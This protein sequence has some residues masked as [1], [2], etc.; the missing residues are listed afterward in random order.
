MPAQNLFSLVSLVLLG[1]AV[2]APDSLRLSPRKAQIC[3]DQ[4]TTDLRCYT[5]P[6]NTPQNVAVADVEYVATY[7]RAYGAQIKA[8]RLYTMTAANAPDCDE[9][10]I[11]SHGSAMAVAKHLDSSL[12]SSV[13]FSDIA[14]TIDGGAKATTA[15]QAAA[16][17]GC[18]TDGGSLGVVYNASNPAYL[19]STYPAGSTPGGILIKMVATGA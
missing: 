13:L 5:A 11:Y 1:A 9:W 15:Q 18:G 8:G 16:L 12:N 19:A 4:E 6:G 3:Y 10:T 14:N 2:A 7:L 17:I